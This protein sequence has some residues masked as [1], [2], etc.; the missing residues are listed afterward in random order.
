MN[1]VTRP[2]VL[3]AVFNKAGNSP[4]S[5]KP[6]IGFSATVMLKCSGF[7]LGAFAPYV[8]DEVQL[9]MSVKAAKPE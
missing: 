2:V 3:V 1:G 9:V 8:S 5:K 7:N 4:L 6:T